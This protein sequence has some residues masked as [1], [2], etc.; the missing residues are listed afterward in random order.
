MPRLRANIARAARVLTL[1]SLLLAVPA[2]AS[3]AQFLGGFGYPGYGGLGMGYGGY[4]LGLGYGGLGMG[5]LGM[6]GLGYGGYGMGFP[7]LG[8]GMGLGY[9]G[10]GYGMGLGY[11]GLGR[12][13][14]G[15]GGLGWGGF[16]WGGFGYPFFGW[17]YGLP[18]T[19]VNWIGNY[20]V[21]PGALFASGYTNP[22]F[23][24]GLSP[25]ATWTAA[26]RV[27][28][29]W[30]DRAAR[31]G[32]VS[33][34]GAGIPAAGSGYGYGNGMPAG[35]PV[36]PAG[37]EGIPARIDRAPAAPTEAPAPAARTITIRTIRPNYRIL[38]NGFAPDHR[39][40]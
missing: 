8:Y 21:G 7:G 26:T 11:G 5:G 29:N 9:G 12:F 3:R 13:G 24:F 34:P 19:G 6:G 28:L 4:G 33:L 38:R 1:S 31:A 17:G 27:Y 23:A 32:T 37:A 36:A 20:I 14:L 30:L 22:L 15:W 16:G 35:A 2:G 39:R 10:L 40:E 25:L 18:G